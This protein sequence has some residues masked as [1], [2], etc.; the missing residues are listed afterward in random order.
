MPEQSIDSVV[1]EI[2]TES[3]AAAKNL[4]AV[5]SALGRLNANSR[6]TRTIN[7]LT[8]LTAAV[9]GMNGLESAANSITRISTAIQGLASVQKLSGLNSAV[10]T[11]SKLPAAIAG[12]NPGVLQGLAN[13]VQPLSTA[14]ESLGSVEKLAGL[15]S[16]I[17]TL[18]KLPQ[19][20]AALREMDLGAF[21]AQ[22]Q[23]LSNAMAPLASNMSQVASG[24][25]AL[26]KNAQRAMNAVQ[27]F[28]TTATTAAT[29]SGGLASAL[30][31]MFKNFSLAY[32][33][34]KA[35]DILGSALGNFN[36]YVE[37]V[38]LFRVSMGDLADEA[39]AAAQKMEDVLGIDSSAAMRNM[40]VIQNLVT[41][42][43]LASD[44]AYVLSENLTQL[45][46]D[47][48][49]FF[50]I[51]IEDSFQK[52]QA[53]ISGELEP[54]RRLGV[55]ISEARLQ[56][57]LWERGIDASVSSLSQADKAILRYIAIM[58][59]TT[60]AQTDMARTLNSPANQIR[61]FQQ[62]ITLL[63]RSIGSLL[64]PMLNAILPPL[65]A[66]VQVIREAIQAIAGFFGIQIEFADVTSS[67]GSSLGGV[68]SGIEDVGNSAAAA[69]E[70]VR[71]LIGGF[72]EL[73]VLPD[74]TSGSGGGGAGGG[75]SILGDLEL[76][77]YDMFDGLSEKI[78]GEVEKI[79]SILKTI[80]PIVAGIGAAFLAWKIG[81]AVL[82]GVGKLGTLLDV[83]KV[84]A[85]KVAAF[86]SG[87]FSKALANV[88]G[89]VVAA[90]KLSPLVAFSAAAAII[91]AQ[92]T[93]LLL[94]SEKFRNGLVNAFELA[95]AGLT[96]LWDGIVEGIQ[97]AISALSDLGQQ[98]LGLIP[99]EVKDSVSLFF[100]TMGEVV[101]KLDLNIGDLL[102]TIAGI[103]LLLIP[104]GRV[105][106]L[107]VLGF[108]AITVAV[109][110]LG[111]AS[112]EEME[113][114]KNGTKAVFEFI[115]KFVTGTISAVV[116][117]ITDTFGGLID[118]LQ[119]I[120]AGNWEQAFDGIYRAT[121]SIITGIGTFIETVFGVDVLAILESAR[122][123]F[124]NWA[125]SVKDWVVEKF[126]ELPSAIGDIFSNLISS[127]FNWGRDMISKLAEGITSF[128]IGAAA[129]G[130]ADK[131]ASFI[132]FSRPDAGP[133]RPYETWMPDM[134]KGLARSLEQKS[135]ILQ[136]AVS[137]LSADAAV[138]LTAMMDAGAG[139]SAGAARAAQ[140]ASGGS[141]DSAAILLTLTQMLQLMQEDDVTEVNVDGGQLLRVVK[142]QA[143]QEQ[144]RTGRNPLMG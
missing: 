120:F 71:E 124:W 87:T 22:M 67:A 17:N 90:F 123:A 99:Q 40:G 58:E 117:M 129:R 70:E 50:N 125:I 107:A 139:M 20:A 113:E 21:A 14:F 102:T 75:G 29:R 62:Q 100:Q 128:D 130:V 1:I 95:K 3:S 6:L 89:G 98:I 104:G 85:S 83:A 138:S 34:N 43:G 110:A 121:T 133:L 118:F 12:I 26:P 84:S 141:D 65:I 78:S 18:G 112:D 16:A 105:A 45:G 51:S 73:N 54:I 96:G 33:A 47:M 56:Q 46:Y 66:V 13:A 140:Q 38:N 81:N 42:F 108:E 60:N 114:L 115:G 61:I 7:N 76:P 94:N 80:L 57:E 49:S 8:K 28:S 37:N 86:L 116:V 82:N 41:S 119:G 5:A 79:K 106:G 59:Q 74:P 69:S 77:S 101:D 134:V 24:F 48:S 135:Y 131:I 143:A 36:D 32:V 144:M 122:D 72:D 31:G 126:R 2:S 44:K 19:V 39:T 53:A 64:I 68:S 103:A 10:N 109:R 93:N 55:D 132:H 142:R 27:K 23:Q 92:F 63:S 30:S 11:L 25:A 136:D 52:L 111:L 88:G 91:V 35:W 137:G 15:N 9:R 4:D 97:P 127:A